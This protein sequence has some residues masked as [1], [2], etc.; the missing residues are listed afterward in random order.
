M[1]KRYIQPCMKDERAQAA[2]IL[3]GSGVTGNDGIGYGGID[4][5]GTLDPEAKES[6]WAIWE[7]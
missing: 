1:K 6:A 4:N 7:E 3:A 2:E 5:N